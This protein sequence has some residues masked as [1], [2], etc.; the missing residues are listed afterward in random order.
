MLYNIML[1]LLLFIY[2]D[3]HFVLKG[4]SLANNSLIALA[5]VGEI[6]D[7]LICRTNLT[8]CC[9]MIPNRFGQFYYPSGTAVPINKEREG[10]YRN[11]GD[12]EIR[13]HRREGVS[14]PTGRFRCEIP[15]SNMVV[16][17]LFITLV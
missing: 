4:R 16:R 9:G 6:E 7:A 1:V 3:I 12:Q 11:R 17:N 15:D 14:S 13:L 8:Q 2:T 5:D 10:F